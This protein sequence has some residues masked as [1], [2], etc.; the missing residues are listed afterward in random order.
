MNVVV[1]FKDGDEV[2]YEYPCD[3]ARDWFKYL[4]GVYL[5]Y[6][7]KC[8]K[9]VSLCDCRYSILKQFIINY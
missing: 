3:E 4:V 6:G 5:D 8:I 9:S 1:T 7:Y 2:V